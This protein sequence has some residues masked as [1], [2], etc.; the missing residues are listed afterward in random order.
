MR[1]TRRASL[2]TSLHKKNA[3]ATHI[4][5]LLSKLHDEKLAALSDL[6]E[7]VYINSEE[8]ACTGKAFQYSSMSGKGKKKNPIMKMCRLT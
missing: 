7:D 2:K 5:D 1:K 3:D 6:P 8:V 4:P